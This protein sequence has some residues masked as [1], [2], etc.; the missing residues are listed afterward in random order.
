MRNIIYIVLSAFFVFFRDK[1]KKFDKYSV[2]HYYFLKVYFS[3]VT[4]MEYLKSNEQ[5][6]KKS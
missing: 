2:K 1:K 3:F 6:N 4:Y 5:I